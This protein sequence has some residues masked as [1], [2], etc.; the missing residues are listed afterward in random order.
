LNL[1]DKI[2]SVFRSQ[3][4]AEGEYRGGPYTLPISGGTLSAEAGQYVN[5]WQMG[6][7]VDPSG[8]RSAM[9]EACVA[10]YAQTIAMCPGSHWQHNDAD[11]RTRV[12]NSALNRVIRKPNSYQ[13]ISDFML[14]LVYAMY[15]GNAYI[16]ATRNNRFEISELHLFNSRTSYAQ[17]AA[18]GDVFYSLQGN[19]I[20][21]NALGVGGLVVPARDVIHIRLH[22]PRHPL[23]GESPMVAAALQLTAGAAALQQQVLFYANQARPS[24][25]LTTDAILSV[26]QARDLRAIW[27]EQSK[28][29]NAGKTPV[30]SGGLKAQPMAISSTDSQLADLLKLSD[31]ALANV[32]RVPLQILGIGN[33]A[34]SSTESL[35]QFWL[36]SGLGFALNHI[37]E[38]FGNAFLLKG[39][40]DE[41]LEYDTSALQ[42]SSF[43][44]R[45]EAWATGT[46]GGVFARNEARADF[47]R[48]PVE[49]GDEPWV[50]QQDVPLSVAFDNAKNPPPAPK[51]APAPAVSDP[52]A[53]PIDPASAKALA[54]NEARSMLRNI[55]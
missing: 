49:G 34:F 3:Q 37:E 55:A 2:L 32:F 13:S 43:K 52:A 20:V 8:G 23:V 36:A 27:D 28:G 41:Y 14:N 16:L 10:A 39:Q 18:N 47:E 7:N 53:E 17:V 1:I 22:C 29:L 48:K 11:G 26:E 5:W 50:Q 33:N 44:E 9:V 51:P 38:A 35:M 12:T 21:E 19:E 6:Y 15:D 54:Q 45:V 46:K 4:Y 24:F 25:L 30:L 40:P 42:R 31:Q